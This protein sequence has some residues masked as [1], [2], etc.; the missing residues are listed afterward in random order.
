M[1]WADRRT[2]GWETRLPWGEAFAGWA[3][4]SAVL[5]SPWATPESET[6]DDGI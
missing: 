5:P 4:V 1:P 3:G 2:C 6:L